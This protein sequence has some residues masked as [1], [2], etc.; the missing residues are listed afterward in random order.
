[1]H[2][3]LRG[4]LGPKCPPPLVQLD[5]WAALLQALGQLGLTKAGTGI[6]WW[7]GGLPPSVY[8]LYLC[9]ILYIQGV[10]QPPVL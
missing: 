8:I 1:M 10:G 6:S 2:P 7:W 9:N 4:T 3:L 5:I